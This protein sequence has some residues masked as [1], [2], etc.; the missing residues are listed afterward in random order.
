MANSED[1]NLFFMLPELLH[2][3][4]YVII[5][6]KLLALAVLCWSKRF[7]IAKKVRALTS[8]RL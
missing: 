7:S 8:I 1:K 3:L 5:L 6:L 4:P 2:G